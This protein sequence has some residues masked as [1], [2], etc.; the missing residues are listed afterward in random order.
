MFRFVEG[1]FE[2]LF[3]LDPHALNDLTH[4]YSGSLLQKKHADAFD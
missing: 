1:F 3:K 2:A 4:F